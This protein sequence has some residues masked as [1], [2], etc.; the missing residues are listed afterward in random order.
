MRLSC[1]NCG[2]QYEVPDEVIPAAGRDV[3]CSNCGD[4]WFQKH[5]DSPDDDMA[6]PIENDDADFEQDASDSTSNDPQHDLSGDV[7]G[8]ETIAQ[9]PD[10]TDVETYDQIE[11]TGEVDQM[12]DPAIADEVRDGGDTHDGGDAHDTEDDQAPQKGPQRQTLDP[13]ISDVLREEAAREAAARAS[14]GSNG[15]ESQPDLGLG[16]PEFDGEGGAAMRAQEARVRMARMRGESDPL[17]NTRGETGVEAAVGAAVAG[18]RRDLLPDI[19]EI[20]STLRSTK[21]RRTASDST[22]PASPESL[23]Q[24]RQRRGFRRGF[25]LMVLLMVGL[26]LIYANAPFIT[27]KIP[28]LDT[29]LSL[30]VEKVNLARLWLDAKMSAVLAWLDIKAVGGA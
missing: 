28:Q 25:L 8:D 1:P 6:S 16:E 10:E 18:S 30:Y 29:V 13:A 24:R 22:D 9:N 14:E 27:E 12:V 3:Q 4:T 2:A 19:E 7:S 15:L 21:D 11:S 17:A 20:N 5:K 26:V 23:P